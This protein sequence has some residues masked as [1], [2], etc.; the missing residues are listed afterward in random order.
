[1][2]P[3]IQDVH[4]QI[5]DLPESL[6]SSETSFGPFVVPEDTSDQWGNC[7]AA[8]SDNPTTFLPQDHG[9]CAA[10][11][12]NNEILAHAHT[13]MALHMTSMKASSLERY[14]TYQTM[15][16]AAWQHSHQECMANV[17]SQAQEIECLK[18][19]IK[20]LKEENQQLL[21]EIST[22]RDVLRPA[23]A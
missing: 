9:E 16:L 19:E 7:G 5:E 11:M 22:W 21:E 2:Q 20:E 1:M 18:R 14:Y 12:L 17:Q 3:I 8:H 6:A 13:E 4:H 10:Q 15:A 23:S